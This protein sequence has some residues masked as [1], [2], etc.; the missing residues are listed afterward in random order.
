MSA[1]YAIWWFWPVPIVPAELGVA[2]RIAGGVIAAFGAGIMLYAVWRFHRAGTTPTHGEPTTTIVASGPYR[3]TR[4]PMYVGMVS[5][6]GGLALLGNALWP[7]LVLVP[8]IW[9]I[10]TQVIAREERYLEAKFWRAVPRLQG[11]GPALA[12]THRSHHP[13]ADRRRSRRVARDAER[14]STPTRSAPRRR[15]CRRDST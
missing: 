9:I 11:P 12:L 15:P 5:V 4:N 7:L 13:P 8:A 10:Q 1:G 3:F 6:Q 2:V 14:R